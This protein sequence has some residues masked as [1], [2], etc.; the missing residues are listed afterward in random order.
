MNKA[1]LTNKRKPGERY[2]LT[3]EGQ[4]IAANHQDELRAYARKHG[5]EVVTHWYFGPERD[6][7][8]P[9]DSWTHATHFSEVDGK[10]KVETKCGLPF[11]HDGEH[12]ESRPSCPRCA[13]IISGGDWWITVVG[14]GQEYRET[15]TVFHWRQALDLVASLERAGCQVQITVS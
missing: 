10:I 9:P 6:A 11:S 13:Q 12:D 15:W 7:C 8:L 1:I 3:H 5:L 4:T 2:R 14:E